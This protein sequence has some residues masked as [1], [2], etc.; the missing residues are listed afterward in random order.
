MV[1]CKL[2]TRPGF[3]GQVHAGRGLHAVPHQLPWSTHVH[4]GVCCGGEPRSSR[5]D[6]CL[7]L[8]PLHATVLHVTRND[9]KIP[10]M[11]KFPWPQAGSGTLAGRRFVQAVQAAMLCVRS[12][13]SKG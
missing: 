8:D 12:G 10:G 6:W 11:Q 9:V 4:G 13:Q 2:L 5:H 1:L 3:D 7:T